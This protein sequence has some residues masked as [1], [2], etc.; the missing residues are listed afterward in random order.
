MILPACQAH[1]LA[2]SCAQFCRRVAPSQPLDLVVQPPRRTSVNRL[3]RIPPQRSWRLVA[4][5]VPAR[6]GQGARRQPPPG[7]CGFVTS[8]SGKWHAGAVQNTSR[9]RSLSNGIQ[10]N[11]SGS[12]RSRHRPRWSGSR[13][14][15][16]AR[17]HVQ[18]HVP[19]MQGRAQAHR[20]TGTGP[21]GCGRSGHRSGTSPSASPCTGPAQVRAQVRHKSQ[22]KSV[23]RSG[24]SPCT[25]PAQVRHKSW[26]TSRPRYGTATAI[27][28]CRGQA[29]AVHTCWQLHGYCRPSRC[30]RETRV[31]CARAQ[32]TLL[33]GNAAAAPPARPTAGGSSRF[34]LSAAPGRP[35]PSCAVSPMTAPPALLPGRRCSRCCCSARATLPAAATQLLPPPLPAALTPW[36]C[37]P[38]PP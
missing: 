32:S 9:T 15:L 18:A 17:Q 6:S 2:N 38:S 1:S 4:R 5:A 20:H 25:G 8:L 24:T 14:T 21:I 31:I 30:G 35:L 26:H 13:A 23:H 34:T 37:A 7:G 22:R 28:R 29:R 27:A 16:H 11:P 33:Q 10:P 3:S 36:G 12:S 19:S